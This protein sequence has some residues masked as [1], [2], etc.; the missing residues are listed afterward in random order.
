MIGLLLIAA[1]WLLLRLEGK[2][3]A[4]LGFNAP[5]VRLRQF[6]AGFAVAGAVV[7]LQQLALSWTTGIAWVHNEDFSFALAREHLRWNT[8]SVLY[9]ELLFRGYLLYQAI[10]WLGIRRAVLL[11]AAA[12]GIYHWFSYGIFGNPV[13]MGYVFLLTGSFGLMTALAFARTKSVAAPIG[14]HL[15]WNVVSQVV[16][17]SGPLGAAWLVP[18]NGAAHIEAPGLFGLLLSF[19]LPLLFVL[20]VCLYLQRGHPRDGS[21]AAMATAPA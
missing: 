9:E 16:F 5:A 19:V 15:G 7:V 12:F 11:D 20:G 8:N 6:A 10:R 17:S 2:R 3:L 18:A 21:R 1:S 14:L 13:V 4:V